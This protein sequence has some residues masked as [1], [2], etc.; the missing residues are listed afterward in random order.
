MLAAD[1][2]EALGIPRGEYVIKV[3]NRKVLDG[4]LGGIGLGGDE[5]AA[6]GSLCCAPSTNWTGLART[7][8]AQLL[9]KGRKDESGD[10]TKGAGLDQTMIARLSQFLAAWMTQL[11]VTGAI[12][13][14]RSDLAHE[15]D[16]RAQIS[17]EFADLRASRTKAGRELDQMSEIDAAGYGTDRI[18]D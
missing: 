12:D 14:K 16:S 5:N 18:I 4:V 17:G 2:M 8:F 7:A 10:F 6:S 11:S 9:G 15:R 3:N 13:R 1:T